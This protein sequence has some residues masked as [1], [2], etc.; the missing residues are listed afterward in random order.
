MS[1]SKVGATPSEVEDPF[2]MLCK[3]Q[4]VGE[5]THLFLDLSVTLSPFNTQQSALSVPSTSANIAYHP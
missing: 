3:S 1:L 5:V 4:Q 2:L